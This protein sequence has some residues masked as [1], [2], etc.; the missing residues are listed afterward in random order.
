MLH[1]GDFIELP[2]IAIRS[3][4]TREGWSW[5]THDVI[6]G[7]ARM[8]AMGIAPRELTL[9]LLLHVQFVSPR[10][11]L[12]RLRR[13]AD[14]AEPFQIWTSSGGY[15]GTF[16]IAGLDHRP[17]WTFPDGRILVATCDVTLRDPGVEVEV[18][19]RPLAL[20]QTA[21]DIVSTPVA[22]DTSA[23]IDDVSPEE[24]ARI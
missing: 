14:T 6:E 1:L 23:D 24:I 12:T 18:A 13:I 22:E 3:A 9:S 4:S 16:I 19:E 20:T 11:T 5:A 2:A 15:W 17:L 10:P 21:Q 7:V 8:Q